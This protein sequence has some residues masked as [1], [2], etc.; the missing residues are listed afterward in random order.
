GY[1]C[2]Q[3][4]LLRQGR[5][6]LGG[7]EFDLDAGGLV[8]LVGRADHDQAAVGAGHRALDQHDVVLGVDADDAQVPRGDALVAVL[9]R[10]ADALLGP[11]ATA[12]AGVGRDTTALP[13][14]LLDAVA[15][16][17][18]AEVV[19]LHRAGEAAALAGADHVHLLG[20]LE[21]VLRR[22]HLADG[23]VRVGG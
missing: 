9:A 7:A 5:T 10:H 13:V 19:A 6:L 1:H 15:A 14:A 11:A 17:E 2:I 20:V 21:N 8:L 4:L 22:Q 16:A 18:A 12:V 3:L 23:Q